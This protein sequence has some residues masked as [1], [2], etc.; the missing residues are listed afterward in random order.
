[1]SQDF[2]FSE[3]SLH[4]STC[5][6]VSEAICTHQLRT[7]KLKN[8]CFTCDEKTLTGEK[9]EQ[10]SA[11]NSHPILE[12]CDMDN[13]DLQQLKFLQGVQNQTLTLNHENFPV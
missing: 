7:A 9:I 8:N 5:L 2:T 4:D 1:M 6:S 13:Y 11:R 12:L 3:W 10:I